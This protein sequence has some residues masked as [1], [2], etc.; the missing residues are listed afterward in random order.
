MDSAAPGWSD[1]RPCSQ[2]IITHERCGLACATA[3]AFSAPGKVIHAPNAGLEALNAWNKKSM[4]KRA[5]FSKKKINSCLL[6]QSTRFSPVPN[7]RRKVII[8][9][10]T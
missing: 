9:Y 8:L 4:V 7:T 2:S 10:L 6:G 1:V 3:R 5:L